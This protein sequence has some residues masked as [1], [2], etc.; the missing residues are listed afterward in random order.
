MG[1]YP[2]QSSPALGNI[3]LQYKIDYAVTQIRQLLA[4]R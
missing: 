2:T 4:A 1:Q 3:F